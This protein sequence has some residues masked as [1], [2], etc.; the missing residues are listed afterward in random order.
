MAD[1]QFLI[2]ADASGAIKSIQTVSKEI[3]SVSEKGQKSSSVFS[4]LWGQISA[5]VIAANLVQKGLAALKNSISS[6]IQAAEGQET[7]EKRLAASLRLTG[8][9]VSANVQHFKELAS[10]IQNTTTFGDEAVLGAQ[11]LLVQMTRL[12]REGLEQAIKGAIGLSSVLGT[13]LQSAALLVAK[14]VEGNTAVLTRYGIKIDE[15]LSAEEKRRAVLEKLAAMYGR[16]EAETQTFAGTMAQLKN[17]IGDLAEEVG[18]AIVKN[19]DFRRAI[20]EIRLVLLRMIPEIKEWMAGI[21]QF[22]SAAV[23]AAAWMVEQL[24]RLRTRIGGYSSDVTELEKVINSLSASLGGFSGVVEIIQRRLYAL[25]QTSTKEFKSLSELSDK[26]WES[27]NEVG[28]V[29]TI[30]AIAMGKFGKEVK[31]AFEDVAGPEVIKKLQFLNTQGIEPLRISTEEL[32]EQEKKAKK[33]KEDL[34]KA[35]DDIY[36][37]IFPFQAKL[38]EL[39][40]YQRILN[41]AFSRGV[42][43]AAEYRNA[44]ARV[45]D[46][47]EKLTLGEQVASITI[48]ASLEKTKKSFQGLPHMMPQIEKSVVSG[49]NKIINAITSSKDKINNAIGHIQNVIQGLNAIFSQIHA[50]EEIRIE[51]EYKKRLATI[52]KTIT[53]EEEKQKAIQALEA[54]YEIRKTEAKR[55]A[56]K[57]EKAVAIFSSIIETARAVTEALPNLGLA[58]VVAAMG[59]AKTAFIAAQPI[60]LATGAVF[61]KPTRLLSETGRS[62]LVGEAGTE[63]LL[64]ENKLRQIIRSE[65]GAGRGGGVSVVVPISL[66]I[67]NSTLKKEIIQ[68]FNLAQK[69]GEIRLDMIRA[70]I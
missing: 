23:Q 56:A 10:R 5:G 22:A 63:I 24:E 60:P 52:E 19:E 57:E 21:A 54:E 37:A 14:A 53:N 45:Q 15:N 29:A 67:G 49:W 69:T 3:D 28:E 1:I 27:F 33:E 46:E 70:T 31:K 58:A 26:L 35:Y 32:L 64:P 8:R 17:T 12:N 36:K 6:V 38:K 18:N 62:Y 50:N 48:I 11:A 40:E 47:I 34:K 13:D 66:E 4:S 42:I 65:L 61:E 59:A 39:I 51:N 43:S 25:G 20:A 7:A 30:Q 9:E 68:K 16:A 44:M 41:E 2:S 55:K